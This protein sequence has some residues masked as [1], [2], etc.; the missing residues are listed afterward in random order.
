[1]CLEG[2]INQP[3]GLC[4]SNNFLIRKINKE[5]NKE[6]I[7]TLEQGTRERRL[8]LTC[9]RPEKVIPKNG[10]SSDETKKDHIHAPRSMGAAR[11]SYP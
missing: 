5:N 3:E 10:E 9:S 1:M 7:S 11:R 8:D 4:M 6:N 2:F